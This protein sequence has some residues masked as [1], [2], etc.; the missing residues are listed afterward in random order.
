[1]NQ[2]EV[3]HKTLSSHFYLIGT[4]SGPNLLS[5]R[6]LVTFSLNYEDLTEENGKKW[7]SFKIFFFFSI[8]NSHFNLFILF[9][10][11]LYMFV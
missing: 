7:Y 8:F 1:M 3:F 2:K 11:R 6:L 10:L 4:F 5:L 9:S